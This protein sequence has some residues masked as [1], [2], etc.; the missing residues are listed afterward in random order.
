[1]TTLLVATAA[2]VVGL[3]LGFLGGRGAN[4]PTS[5]PPVGP[6]QIDL[7]RY[8]LDVDP[9]YPPPWWELVPAAVE[10]PLDT[11]RAF[12]VPADSRRAAA[13]L[14]RVQH[15]AGQ[16]TAEGIKAA[17]VIRVDEH[18]R[19][20]LEDG[21]HRLEVA[22]LIGARSWPVRFEPANRIT[23]HGR[24][25]LGLVR[26]LAELVKADQPSGHRSEP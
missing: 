26:A 4:R 18:G 20:V 9:P 6:V 21:H 2:L 15:I 22:G 7:A 19:A 25:V 11:I 12:A 13:D 24:P 16:I 5:P 8:Q 23:G 17:M 3:T 1:M 14:E 10:L